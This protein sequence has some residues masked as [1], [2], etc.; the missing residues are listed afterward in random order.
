VD[1]SLFMA[2]MVVLMSERV[3]KRPGVTPAVFS[4]PIFAAI[5][6]VSMFRVSLPPYLTIVEGGGH[7]I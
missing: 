1:Y 2:V 5:T 4:S 3:E 7:F 6:S